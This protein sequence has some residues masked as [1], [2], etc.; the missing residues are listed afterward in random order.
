MI[1]WPDVT[2]KRVLKETQLPFVLYMIYLVSFFLH[3]PSRVTFLGLIRFD[4]LLVGATCV[5]IFSKSTM[6]GGSLDNASKYLISI[7]LYSIAVLPLVEWPGSVISNGLY[8]F[9][10]GSIFYFFTVTL[11]LSEARLKVT[12]FIF[13]ACSIFR[14][15]EPLYLNL[16]T[17]YLGSST[18]LGE[19]EFAGRLAGAPSDTINPNG[20]AFVIASVFPFLHYVFAPINRKTFTVYVVLVPALLYTMGLTLSRSGVLAL[21]I[22]GFGIFIKSKNKFLLLLIGIFGLMLAWSSL[23]S[24]QK[25]RYLSLVSED[26]KQ[27]STAQGRVTG[28][29]VD[30]E[31]AMNKPIIGHGL[32]TSREANWNVAGK[33]QISHMLWTEIWQEIGLIGLALF[34][35]YLF[36]IFK[37]FREAS[38]LIKIHHSNKEFLYRASQAMHVWLLMNLLFSFASYGLK[39][40]EWYLFG[41]LSVSLLNAVRAGTSRSDTP[42]KKT[43][44]LCQERRFPLA[45]KIR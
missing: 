20:L 14:V 30:F 2:Q 17:G 1:D 6:R 22:I 15:F 34:A 24:V 40:Y 29:L 19:G 26:T 31:V 8:G 36:A 9:L 45:R 33:D 11:V 5:L 27:A 10:K 7:F 39:S 16:T 35:L 4:L 38:N 43:E 41:G 28:W 18:Y 44:E 32:G 37:N 3:V 25:D 42:S 12:I 21:G 23:D 13:L